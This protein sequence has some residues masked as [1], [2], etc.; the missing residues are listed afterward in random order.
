LTGFS[1][2]TYPSSERKANVV[3]SAHG[4]SMRPF[5]RYF[6]DLIIDEMMKLVNPHD[7]C[8]DYVVEF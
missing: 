4:N 1:P 7:R 8:F 2:R 5:R 6:E 3:I